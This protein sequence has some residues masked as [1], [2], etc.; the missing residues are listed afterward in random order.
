MEINVIITKKLKQL[1]YK[2][3]FDDDASFI[4]FDEEFYNKGTILPQDY[5][6]FLSQ[7][8]KAGIFDNLVIFRPDEPS[9]W[10]A[11]GV[12][13]F[14]VLYGNCK[15]QTNDIFD[16]QIAFKGRIPDGFF[17]IGE[18]QG[19]NQIGMFLTPNQYGA[20]YFWDHQTCKGYEAGLYRIANSFSDFILRLEVS[21]FPA[22]LESQN[23]PKL[24]SMTTTGELEARIAALI[25]KK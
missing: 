10:A 22:E 5:L 15:L 14:S 20:I 24:I 21:D 17:L 6:E 11:D 1:S 3:L 8:P 4:D 7:N 23:E 16:V 19:G 2:P 25:A 13:D 9:P 12:E 18:S